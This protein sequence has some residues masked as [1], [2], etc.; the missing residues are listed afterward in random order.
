MEFLVDAADPD[1]F[2]FLEMNTRLQVEHPVTEMLLGVDL[3]ELQL[4]AAED[5][6]VLGVTAVGEGG[7]AV[8]AR[9]YAEDPGDDYRPQSGVL[10]RVEIPAP[11]GIRVDAGY[12]TGS[13][14]ST[15]Y[16][17]MLAKVIAHAPHRDAAI[18]LLAD[19]LS[20][21]RIHGVVTNRDLL[22]EVLRSEAF[23]AAEVS[24]SLLE[25]G[26][27]ET[28]ASARSS[29][30]GTEATGSHL[31]AALALASLAARSRTVQGSIPTGWRNVVSQPHR[32]VFE[33]DVMVEWWGTRDGF[34][35][36][37]LD[38]VTAAPDRVVLDDTGV[39]T[40]YDVAITGDVVEVDSV[41]GHARLTR[42]PRYTD[43]AA[44]VAS[45]SLL[46]PMPGTVVKV[47][48]DAGDAVATGDPVLVLEAMKMQH[49]VA[50]PHAG[51]VTQIDVQPG[52]Q[53]AAGEVLAV[54]EE[55][56]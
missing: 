32:T 29:T 17:A 6:T 42:L 2:W 20:R 35:V 14:V 52:A 1:R 8:E 9:L 36:E 39:R 56:E 34:A 27:F 5:P 11:D 53:V 7:H 41:H 16:D 37:G 19:T 25:S 23:G 45:G 43:P 4:S 12:A 38:V 21:A 49:T 44:A 54:V 50:A 24:T 22:V 26:G 31:A 28:L 55:Q 18:R 30:A 33:G 40:A 15:H 47:E 13:T 3:V 10:T 46:A 48:V 51:T